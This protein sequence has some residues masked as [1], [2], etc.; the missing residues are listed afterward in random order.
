VVNVLLANVPWVEGAVRAGS[1]WPAKYSKNSAISY[2]PFPFYMGYTAGLL[3]KTGCNLLVLDC[4]ATRMSRNE[5]FNKCEEFDPD[6]TV[7]ETA[8]TSFNN[9]IEICKKLK[10]ITNTKIA[11]TGTHS[12]VFYKEILLKYPF[13]D[14]VAVGEY[15]LTIL[16]LVESMQ[17]GKTKE[18]DGLAFRRGN[19]VKFKPRPLLE[20]LDELPFPAWHLFPMDSYKSSDFKYNT[21]YS[22]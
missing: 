18:I 3:E 15:E 2:N 17:K 21:S 13:I 4:L 1:R 22:Y 5:F 8:T 7:V 9:D 16:N 6:L 19:S 11:L 10:N 12:T 14:F 20:N